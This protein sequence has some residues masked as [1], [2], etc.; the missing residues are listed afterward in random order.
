MKR[1]F[2]GTELF[3]KQKGSP[4]DLFDLIKLRYWVLSKSM[5]LRSKA[6]SHLIEIEIT[7]GD[8]NQGLGGRIGFAVDQ[9][10]VPS[11]LGASASDSV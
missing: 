1:W 11:E 7:E 4:F 10:N 8:D 6:Y 9:P 2:I 5:N 3:P